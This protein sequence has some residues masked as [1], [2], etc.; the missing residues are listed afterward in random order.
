MPPSADFSQFPHPG[1]LL[2]IPFEQAAQYQDPN[3]MYHSEKEAQSSADRVSACT[4]APSFPNPQ[5][6][7]PQQ[8][9]LPSRG[10]NLGGPHMSSPPPHLVSQGSP[11]SGNPV[12]LHAQ[13]H[14]PYNQNPGDY[15]HHPQL[16]PQNAH[17]QYLQ[18]G[19]Q[20]IIDP[21]MAHLYFPG[22]MGAPQD[23]RLQRVDM[24]SPSQDVVSPPPAGSGT[25]TLEAVLQ[26]LAAQYTPKSN[27]EQ[28]LKIAEIEASLAK[29]ID[30][31][32]YRLEPIESAKPDMKKV[33]LD[34]CTYRTAE[35]MNK[36]PRIT[37][38]VQ[39]LSAED[40]EKLKG[41]S[42]A[43]GG[44]V[45]PDEPSEHLDPKKASLEFDAVTALLLQ[46]LGKSKKRESEE[47]EGKSSY[48]V[49]KK[50][51]RVV[52]STPSDSYS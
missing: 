21:S 5:A 27:M 47:R 48:P 31:P 40:M 7:H 25:P 11:F 20:V 51:R 14:L 4:V 43:T 24:Q 22:P 2:A 52:V 1:G 26:K 6:M 32:L 37:K 8:H 41:G 49:T 12:S 29:N 3:W 23:P 17:Q 50:I 9:L 38:F 19:Q 35:E 44:V 10:V 42:S 34:V 33:Y 45:I 36:D 46:Q 18:T 30:P 15:L 16:A 39:G 28:A 13:Q